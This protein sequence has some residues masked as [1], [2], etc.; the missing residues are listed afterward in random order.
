MKT[1]DLLIGAALGAS[2]A[3]IFDPQSGRRRRAI[4]RD[5]M[6]RAVRRGEVDDA[7][8]VER[9]RERLGRVC[10]HPLAIDVEAEDG[11]VTLRGVLLSSEIN[12][13]LGSMAAVRGVRN[14]L[15]E[16]EPHDSAD[17][18]PYARR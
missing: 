12:G 1:T 15:N 14:L 17:S 18:I 5:R 9:L 13:V 7:T 3:F 4:V 6:A 2:L 8:L 11:D 10:S 16:L